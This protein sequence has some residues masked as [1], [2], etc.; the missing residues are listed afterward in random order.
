[1]GSAY[2]WKKDNKDLF[3]IWGDISFP[4]AFLAETYPEDI[5]LQKQ[6]MNIYNFDIEAFSLD[7]IN[8][9]EPIRS[10]T[11]HH[12]IRDVYYVFGLKDYVPPTSNIKYLKFETEKDML[13]SIVDFFIRQDIDILSGFNINGYDIGYLYN[14]ICLILGVDKATS[15]SP[16]KTI[17]KT[18]KMINKNYVEVYCIDGIVCWDFRELYI[19]FTKDLRESYSLDYLSKFHKLGQKVDYKEEYHSLENLYERNHQL[20]I[21]YN[22]HDCTLVTLLDQQ[23]NYITNALSYSYMAK[24]EP[25]NIF[26][27]TNPWDALLYA[28]SIK[29]YLLCPPKKKQHKVDF[30]GGYVKEPNRGLQYWELVVDIVSSY[31]NQIK[32]FNLSPETIV[33]DAV[34]NAN[35]ELRYIRNTYHG[36]TT[37]LDIDSLKEVTNIL[38]KYNLIYTCNGNFFTKEKQGIIP[39]IVAKLFAERI[40]IKKQMKTASKEEYAKLDNKQYTLKI[41]LNSIFGCCASNFFRYFDIRVGEAITWQGQV[42]TRGAVAYLTKKYPLIVWDYGDTDSLFL[43][44]SN[45]LEDRFKGKL[46][47]TRETVEFILKLQE[48]VIEPCIKEFFAKLKS[49]FNMFEMS[50]E[51]ETEGIAAAALFVEKKKYCLSYVYADDKWCVEEPKMKIKGIEVVRTSTPAVVRTKLKDALQMIF[52]KKTNK[53]LIEYSEQFEKEFFRLPF[54]EVASPSGVNIGDYTLQSKS[55]PIAVRAALLYNKALVDYGLNYDPIRKTDKIRYCYIKTP[56]VFHSNVIGCLD[57]MP[58]ELLP[59]FQIDYKTQ[60]F[61][62]FSAPLTKI[63]ALVDYKFEINKST[64]DSFFD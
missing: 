3:E 14:R 62:K 16:T 18:T 38:N 4:V 23:L 52:N 19:K 25:Q 40:A 54:E 7:I 39:R 27:T 56:N 5:E 30:E 61:K 15:I 64:L 51:M 20:F 59:Y 41:F 43:N 13:L 8:T 22:I 33:S 50:I 9:P 10:V 31:P 26:G 57:K 6:Y 53:D 44:L 55:L 63:L 60:Y 21:E 17:I 11:F 32:S 47:P 45:V 1:M 49:T 58:H 35:E 42:S 29:D 28:E 2:K 12:M 34:V 37:V 48:K 46:P 24:C 36:V